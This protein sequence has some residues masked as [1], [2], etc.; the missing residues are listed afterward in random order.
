MEKVHG[1]DGDL[2]A[3]NKPSSNSSHRDTNTTTS[4]STFY[5]GGVFKYIYSLLFPIAAI[6]L[7]LVVATTDEVLSKKFPPSCVFYEAVRSF[8]FQTSI[9][10]SFCVSL[11]AF[12]EGAFNSLLYFQP[13]LLGNDIPRTTQKNREACFRLMISSGFIVSNVYLLCNYEQVSRF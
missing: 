10:V 12:S 13:D 1:F 8:R 3:I 11:N 4:E 7:T 6:I 9:A 2:K 5:D